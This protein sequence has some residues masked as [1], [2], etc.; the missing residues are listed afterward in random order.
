M[1][2]TDLATWAYDRLERRRMT[3]WNGVA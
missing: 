2:T 3:D 1:N